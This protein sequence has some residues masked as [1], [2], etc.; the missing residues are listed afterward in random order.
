VDEGGLLFTRVGLGEQ[1]DGGQVLG[2]VVDP[3]GGTRQEVRAMQA[4]RVIGMA[5]SQVVIPGFAAFHLAIPGRPVPGE[6]EPVGADAADAVGPL[7]ID[8]RPE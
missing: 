1:V 6:P 5:W 2:V 3:L 4:G 7:E 8:E